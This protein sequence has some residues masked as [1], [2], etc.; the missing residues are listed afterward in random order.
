MIQAALNYVFIVNYCHIAKTSTTGCTVQNSL[1]NNIDLDCLATYIP[2][3]VLRLTLITWFNVHLKGRVRKLWRD[4]KYSGRK[5]RALYFDILCILILV[6][7]K[8]MHSDSTA[9]FAVWR[10]CQ[11]ILQL[12]RCIKLDT[13]LVYLIYLV[14]YYYGTS[15]LVHLV[16][17]VHYQYGTSSLVYLIYL[18]R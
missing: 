11:S 15:S 6:Q 14:H 18:V 16:Y 9:Q 10:S 5:F 4:C 12:L 13:Y 2:C 8:T 7:Q 17:L 3:L 1:T